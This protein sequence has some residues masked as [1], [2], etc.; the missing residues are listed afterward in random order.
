MPLGTYDQFPGIDSGNNFA[1]DV[2][3]ALLASTDVKKAISDSATDIAN[4]K[5]KAATDVRQWYNFRWTNA[6]ART[7]QTGMRHMD[8]GIQLDTGA[9][10]LYLT[11]KWVD[12]TTN[13]NHYQK[14]ATLEAMAA[15]T[16]ARNEGTIATVGRYQWS[17]GILHRHSAWQFQANQWNPIGNRILL[18]AS[19][20][21]GTKQ[22][23]QVIISLAQQAGLLNI[24]YTEFF[25]VVKRISLYWDGGALVPTPGTILVQKQ[26]SQWQFGPA[27]RGD[28]WDP[29]FDTQYDPYGVANYGNGFTAPSAGLYEVSGKFGYINNVNNERVIVGLSPNVGGNGMIELWSALPTI[30]NADTPYPF[31]FTFFSDRGMGWKI[32]VYHSGQTDLWMIDGANNQP[33]A[34]NSG[35]WIK[36][37]GSNVFV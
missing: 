16:S 37:M 2:R 28:W 6:A 5:V 26:W 24:P 11:D 20:A 18:E 7:A 9:E 4:A 23:A 36:F 34:S 1:P 17:T 32:R 31:K 3:T 22:A 27:P 13:Q 14:Y 35:Y 8:K 25:N 10:Y 33:R 29:P 12:M 19:D 30:M 21:P 15:D